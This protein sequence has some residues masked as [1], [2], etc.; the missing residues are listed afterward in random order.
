NRIV[1]ALDARNVDEASRAT[2][3]NA[4]GEGKL[5]HRL[6]ATFGDRACAVGNP[7]GALKGGADGRM[8]LETLE[9]LKRC[10]VGIL[11]VQVN[12]EADRNLIVFKVIEERA[13]TGRAAQR[14][15]ERMLHEAW[16]VV[17]GLDLPKLFHADAEFLR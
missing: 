7:L 1:R 16:L 10:E 8:R 2:H 13:A 5:R 9:F 11:V 6:E 14:P 3:Q 12:D 4:A 15:A 17:L